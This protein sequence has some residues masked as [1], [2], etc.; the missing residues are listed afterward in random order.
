MEPG[1]ALGFVVYCAGMIQSDLEEQD[2]A[3]ESG[4]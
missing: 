2:E 3:N 4:V 1:I